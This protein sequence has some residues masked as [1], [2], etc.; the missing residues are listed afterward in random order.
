MIHTCGAAL[1]SGRASM[2]NDARA[3]RH[4]RAGAAS[5]Q[6]C[7]ARHIQVLAQGMT[8]LS[9]HLPAGRQAQRRWHRNVRGG[10][11][12]RWSS[13]SAAPRRNRPDGAGCGAAGTA[14]RRRGRGTRTAGGPAAPPPA[15]RGPGCRLPGPARIAA[16]GWLSPRQA[17]RCDWKMRSGRRCR[18]ENDH[19]TQQIKGFIASM[20]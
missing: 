16:R 2:T 5:A 13:P 1:A 19:L 6:K 4:A 12:C 8:R 11:A 3:V 18:Y 15:V 9:E 17:W 10:R 7:A 14:R 20:Q